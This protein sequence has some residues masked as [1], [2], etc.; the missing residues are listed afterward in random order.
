MTEP[1][2]S[3][4]PCQRADA[5]VVVER[6]RQNGYVAYFAGGCVRDMLLGLEPQDYDVATDAPPD[7]VRAIFTNTQSVGAAFGVVLVRQKKSVIEVATFRSDGPYL[8]GRRPASVQ[9]VSAE[10]DAR[11]RDFTI[12][13]LFLDPL[14]NKVI[15]F[16]AGRSDLQNRILRAIGDAARRFVEDHLRML[17]AVRFAA[18]FN[19]TIE[20][21]TSAAILRAAPKIK[22]I[23]PERIADELR[24]I[25]TAPTRVTAWPALWNLGLTRQIFRLPETIRPPES[26]H[27]I[28]LALDSHDAIPFPQALAA[29]ALDT[30]T[31][32]EK[33]SIRRSVSA[34]RRNLRIS[35]E[36][37]EGMQAIL[38]D[39]L[40]LLHD[41]PPGLATQK[42]FLA[43]PTSKLSRQLLAALS[44]VENHSPRVALL[45]SDFKA[46]DGQDCAPTPLITGDDLTA[47]GLSPGPLFKPILDAVYD[48]QLEGKIATKEQA[49]ELAMR[50]RA[51]E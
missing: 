27:S 50:G 48:A 15:D 23:S 40:P 10:E 17:R 33:S 3:K 43:H 29:A 34:M 28:F 6:L 16:V 46:L 51:A 20:P 14:E 42:R 22:G 31:D 35:N 2:R 25:L 9:F 26:G 36:E 21:T 4:P 11:R 1:D 49:L 41:S 8:D 12:N 37:S 39:L 13:G 32:L 47:A 38:G 24:K 7:K 19:L 44:S 18:R 5:I 30:G 45:E